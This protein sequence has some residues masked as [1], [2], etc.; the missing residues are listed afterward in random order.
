MISPNTQLTRK[1]L[2]ITLK[3]LFGLQIPVSTLR[4]MSYRGVGPS[5]IKLGSHPY[6][7]FSD[8]CAWIESKCTPQTCTAENNRGICG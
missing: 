1:E 4:V 6:Y 3:E 8:V 5:Y 7:K 2:S